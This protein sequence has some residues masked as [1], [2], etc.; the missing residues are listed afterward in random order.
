MSLG[1]FA[2]VGWEAIYR[3]AGALPIGNTNE[4][5]VCHFSRSWL[6]LLR[7]GWGLLIPLQSVMECWEPW[8]KQKVTGSVSSRGIHVTQNYSLNVWSSCLHHP[9]A[10][11]GGVCH[12]NPTC[13][14]TS[15]C[16]CYLLAWCL[17]SF[18]ENFRNIIRLITCDSSDSF[19]M[20]IS[21]DGNFH[22]RNPVVVS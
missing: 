20:Q 16:P 21:T 4:G 6:S 15:D 22:L 1:L 18:Q 5:Q 3:S 8:L 10:G 11:F 13:T 9:S 17:A 12:P 19:F 14:P 2:R 7:D